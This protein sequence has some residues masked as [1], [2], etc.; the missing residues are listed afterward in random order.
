MRRKL[1]PVPAPD[2]PPA[3]PLPEA[4]DYLIRALGRA[5]RAARAAGVE[6]DV[7]RDAFTAA[8]MWALRQHCIMTCPGCKTPLLGTADRPRLCDDCQ[9][10]KDAQ[11]FMAGGPLGGAS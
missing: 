10:A 5:I 3:P 1:T 7:P 6:D 11:V 8:A 4:G 9:D 2:P